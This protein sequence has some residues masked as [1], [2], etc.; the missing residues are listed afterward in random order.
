[1]SVENYIDSTSLYLKQIGN[2]PL[3]SAEE[4][5]ELAVKIANGDKEAKKKLVNHNLRLVI[6]IANRYK[7]CGV[8]FL[9]LI[10]EGNLGLMTAAEK[11]E[12]EKGFRFSTF[13]TWWVRQYISRA[14]TYQ[15]K[16]IKIPSHIVELQQKIK[17]TSNDFIYSTGREPTEKELAEILNI[18]IDKI[19]TAMDFSHAVTSLDTPVDDDEETTI[20]DLTPDDGMEP[21]GASLIKEANKQIVE[22]VFLSL[23]EREANIIKMRFGIGYDHCLTLEEVGEKFSLSR[24][25]IRQ[26]ETKA[27]RKLRNPMRVQALQE[28]FM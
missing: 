20:G 6:G 15:S 1:M 19:Q 21:P 11:Y 13:A 27:L 7:G 28:A 9:D 26:L 8:S 5:R 18:D 22:E 16:V 10:Q 4:E 12:V 24:E 23:D 2:I 25:R 3:L 17:K 14:I